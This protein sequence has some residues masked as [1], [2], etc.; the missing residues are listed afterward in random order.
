MG[1]ETIFVFHLISC[2]NVVV[3]SVVL[4]SVKR[5]GCVIMKCWYVMIWKQFCVC[6]CVCVCVLRA[7]GLGRPHKVSFWITLTEFQAAYL[8][9]KSDQP[10]YFDNWD[11]TQ[12]ILVV[13][14]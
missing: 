8:L 1:G 5:D 13:S 9:V 10:L 2:L 11:V 3:R 12:H 6:G 14:Y 7:E 4:Y